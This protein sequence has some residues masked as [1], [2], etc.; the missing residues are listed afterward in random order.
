MKLNRHLLLIILIAIPAVLSFFHSGYFTSHDGEWM[1]IRFSDFHRSLADGQFPVRF[2]GRLNFGYGYP[3]FNFL[4]PGTFY[5]A[6]FFHLLKFNFVDSIKL[7]FITSYILSGMCMYLFA[8]EWVGKTQAFVAAVLYLYTPYRFV[9][10]YVRGSLGESVSFLFIPLVFLAVSKI[11]RSHNYV[12]VC[13]GAIGL[14]GLITTHNVIAYLFLPIIVLFGAI[15]VLLKTNNKFFY[16]DFLLLLILGLGLSC[17]FWLPA[18]LEK[19]YTIFDQTVIADYAKNFPL[20]KELIFPSWGFG[21]SMPGKT[22]SMSF[23]LGIINL[24]SL[25]LTAVLLITKKITK[26]FKI[27]VFFF[28]VTLVAIFFLSQVSR[29]FWNFIPGLTLIQ[30]PWRILSVI[31]FTTSIL[32][33]FLLQQAKNKT[34]LFLAIFITALC[35][36]FNITYLKPHF[37]I[38]RG[39]G[40]YSTND[41]TTTVKDEYLPIKALNLP[42]KRPDSKIEMQKPKGQILN[43]ISK[44]NDISFEYNGETNNLLI[45][46]VYFPGWEA[47]INNHVQQIQVSPLGL[48]MIPVDSGRSVVVLKF[49]ESK[50][51]KIADT[52][53]MLSF[54]AILWLLFVSKINKPEEKF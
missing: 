48:M 46:T 43:L 41:D 4:Y 2:A 11:F 35:V 24:I 38:N 22:N 27:A 23:Q 17:F 32:L 47:L 31:T 36:L 3:V 9:D 30:F 28:I 29:F 5:L 50:V 25:L 34:A 54:F 51:R 21:L 13:F 18:V 8:K 16:K 37:F 6:E 1:V 42:R 52:I 53:S 7:L 15:L 19:K 20:F 44:S 45:N 10:M 14:L 40:F 49:K 26:Y 33:G 12:W 39:E